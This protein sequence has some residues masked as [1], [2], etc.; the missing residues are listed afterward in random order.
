MKSGYSCIIVDDEPKAIALLAES[1]TDIYD[2]LK[3]VE[4]CSNWKLAL[5]ALRKTE[6]D[7]VFLDISMPQKTGMDLLDILPDLKAEIIFVTAYSDHAIDAFKYN[8]SGYILKPVN[9]KLLVQAIDKA[10][11]RRQAK[12]IAEQK[13]IIGISVSDKIAIPNNNGLDYFNLT[14]IMF[15]E[16]IARNTKVVA[17]KNKLLS[18]YSIGKFKE[19]LQ[20]QTSFYQVHRS[21]IINLAY[22]K[23]YERQGIIIMTDGSEIPLSKNLRNDFLKLYHNPSS[24]D[25]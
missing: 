17:Q 13:P 22:I 20:L 4:T 10:L 6:V 21:F 7:I 19:M 3:I 1:I 9:D 18:S 15:F 25:I 24:T 2:N 23:R 5:E 12:R 11:E 16:A 14:D 8:T